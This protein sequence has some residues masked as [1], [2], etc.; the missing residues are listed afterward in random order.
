MATLPAAP[1]QGMSR[2]RPSPL[3]ELVVVV[4]LVRVYDWVRTF[5]ALRQ[6]SAERHGEQIRDI[7]RVL[8]ID[9]EHVAN[10]WAA[11]HPTLQ[12]WAAGYYQSAH[13]SVTLGLLAWCWW[14]RPDL[15]RSARN[16]LV[17][18]NLAGLVVFTLLPV[19]PPR[20]LAGGGFVDSVFVA[21]FGSN[22][23][24]PIAADMYAAMPSLHVAW[25][26]CTAYLAARM[27]RRPL[28]RRLCWAYP[29][30]TATVV[31]VTGNHYVLDLLA[32]LAVGAG[33][34]VTARWYER[35]SLRP[36]DGVERSCDAVPTCRSS[37]G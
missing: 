27:I 32:G 28:V 34:V 13:I 25:A 6:A 15:Y 20:L 36:E 18:A 8:H 1:A 22:P 10:A 2:A 16:A 11:R 26:F 9:I 30:V 19:A 24:G 35:R 37:S 7:E 14:Q 33:A 31:V 12:W 29:S 17:L 23:A 21:G 5:A 3:I 4:L